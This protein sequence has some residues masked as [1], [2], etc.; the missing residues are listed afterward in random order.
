MVLCV[1]S[2]GALQAEVGRSSQE[3]GELM[4]ASVQGQT[5]HVI[6]H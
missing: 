2:R 6:Q 4:D 1:C 3:A 5:T